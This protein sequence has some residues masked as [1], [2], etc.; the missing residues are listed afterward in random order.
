MGSSLHIQAELPARPE[1]VMDLLTDAQKIAIWS[2]EAAVLERYEGGRFSMFD[3]W[4]NGT[5]QQISKEELAYTWKVKDWSDETAASLVHIRLKAQGEHTIIT[6]EHKDLPDEDEAA[7]HKVGWYDYFLI[8][9]E[10][11]I[12]I[13]ER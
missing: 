7:A 12:M 13:L 10:D 5:V 4:A 9:L 1:L 6:I 3:G 11:Y 8:P 2:G